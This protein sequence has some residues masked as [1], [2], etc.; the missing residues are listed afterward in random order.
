MFVAG[1]FVITLL[2]FILELVKE[3]KK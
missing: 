2:R 1:N 3:T